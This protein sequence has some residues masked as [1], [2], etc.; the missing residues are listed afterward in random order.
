M[1]NVLY[2]KTLRPAGESHDG[3]TPLRL[4]VTLEVNAAIV[5][6]EGLDRSP[7]M[8]PLRVFSTYHKNLAIEEGVRLAGLDVSTIE[9]MAFDI[10]GL[11]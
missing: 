4:V 11:V 2:S 9:R 6:L 3:E 7:P 1:D 10:G 5:W 8:V